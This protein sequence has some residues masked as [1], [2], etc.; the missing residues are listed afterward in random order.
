MLGEVFPAKIRGWACG[1]TTF[2]ATIYSFLAIKL[3]PDMRHWMGYHNVFT[4][5]TAVVAIGTVT[6]YFCL[7]ETHGKSLQEIEEFF[8]SRGKA[9][10]GE[11]AT[12]KLMAVPEVLV[13]STSN[14]IARGADKTA[15]CLLAR[16]E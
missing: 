8:R 15:A 13:F 7:P 12:K 11:K 3:F 4:L 10:D 2:I 16:P 5:Y 6:M 1:V 14:N 9:A